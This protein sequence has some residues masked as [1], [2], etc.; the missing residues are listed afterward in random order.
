MK[1][2]IPRLA[3]QKLATVMSVGACFAIGDSRTHLRCTKCVRVRRSEI[4][5]MTLSHMVL[6]CR[7]RGFPYHHVETR[8]TF[9]KANHSLI[10][11]KPKGYMSMEENSSSMCYTYEFSSGAAESH[12]P[13][14]SA[15][16]PVRLLRCLS[17]AGPACD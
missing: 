11:Y 12:S 13:F 17:I 15:Q 6:I 4:R 7:H 10:G 8:V 16:H 9:C 14:P 5:K 2:A 3:I 1:N